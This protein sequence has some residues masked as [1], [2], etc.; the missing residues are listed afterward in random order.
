MRGISLTALLA[1]VLPLPLQA[2]DLRH[3]EDAPLRAVQFVDRHE[4]WAAGDD[5][6]V[7][8]TID[9]GKTWERQPTGTRASL[10]GLHFQTPFTGW[11]VGREELP[12]GGGSVGVIL[13]TRDGGLK[14]R[15]V[16][17]NSLPGLY[18]VQFFDEQNG[19]VVGEGNDQFPSGVFRTRDGGRTWQPMPGPRCPGWLDARFQDPETGVLAGAWSRL[20]TVRQGRLGAADVDTLGGRSLSGVHVS[21][22]WAVAVGQGGLV[23]LS[24]TSAGVRWGFA[25]LKLPTELLASLDFHAVH[26]RGDRLWIVG[27][28]GSVVLYSPDRGQTWELRPTGQ[29][30]PLHAVH[31]IDEQTGWAVGDLGTI[32][33]TE[34]GG[35]TWHVQRRGG[36]R[37]AALWVH[38]RPEGLPLDTVALL[39]ADEGYLATALGAV[40]SDP[41]SAPPHRAF[42]EAVWSAA[43]RRVGGAAGEVLWQFPL[44]QHRRQ[45]EARDLI[46]AWDKLH[47]DRAAEH[48]LRQL[49]LALRIWQPELVVTD[50][51]GSAADVPVEALIAEAVR[52]AWKRAADPQQ[53]PEQIERLGLRPCRSAK[54]YMRS[55][56]R[57]GAQV[58]LDLTEAKPRLQATVRDFAAASASLLA[59]RP[60]SLPAQRYYRLLEGRIDGAASHRDLMQGIALAY[61]GTA[62]RAFRPLP[63]SAAELEQAIRA[64]RNL[65]ALIDAPATQLANP[66][67][68]L[69]QLGPTLSQMPDDQAAAAAFAVANHYVR[70]GQWTLARE[71]FLLMVDRYPAHPLAADAYRWLIRYSS[72]SEARRRHELGQ[73]MAVTNVEFRQ[74]PR[75]AGDDSPIQGGVQPVAHRQIALLADQAETRRWYQGALALEA[76]LAGF[77]LLFAQDPAVQFCLQAARRNLGDFDTAR[78]WYQGFKAEHSSSV[79]HSAAAAELWLSNRVGP[80]PRPVLICRQTSSRPFLDGKLDD[81]CWE[82]CKPTLLRDAVG[83]TVQEYVT[84]VRQAFDADFLYVALR[85]RHPEGQRVEPVKVRQRDADLTAHD[86]VS[87]LLD[88]DRDYSTCFHF[89]VDQRGCLSEECWGDAHWNP[90]WFVACHAGTDAWQVEAAIPLVE[91]T[92]DPVTPGKVWAAN[93]VRILPGRGIQAVSVPA[94]V[95]PRPEGLGLWLFQQEPKAQPRE[96]GG[97]P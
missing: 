41:A 36:E 96:G 6:V 83:D 14:W 69:A 57:L 78:H 95:Q 66:N 60:V 74:A 26:G 24:R 64:R 23:L 91:L 19:I 12:H 44:P 9:G 53:F 33:G 92:G 18:R 5:G 11:A 16:S 54:L 63:E 1:V 45:A 76:R 43:M 86:R 59:E 58:V 25:D 71:A 35:R 72:S 48:L 61:E 28:P 80:A 2:N 40:S 39:G 38:A 70:L 51:I 77:G 94:D 75:R 93:V 20:A 67:Q 27:R 32:L 31:F 10:R 34:D 13:V 15:R 81:A 30:L 52:E 62:R 17:L 50:P 73:F 8:H 37:A 7:W 56:Q 4:G 65:Q 29:P 82:G 42:E 89:Q 68:L 47:D 55:P 85:C 88:L 49:V 22:V 3:F 90:R 21:G 46:Q 87:I 84:E 97:K 79:W